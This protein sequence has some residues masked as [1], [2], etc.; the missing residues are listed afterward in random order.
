VRSRAV[1]SWVPRAIANLDAAVNRCRSSATATAAV[2][3][4]AAATTTTSSSATATAE[5]ESYLV[6]VISLKVAYNDR[7]PFDIKASADADRHIAGHRDI[8][9]RA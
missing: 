1:K 3:A 4:T 6:A 2:T 5:V 7:I 9:H 8:C